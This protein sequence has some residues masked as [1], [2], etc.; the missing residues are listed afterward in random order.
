MLLAQVPCLAQKGTAETS[1]GVWRGIKP[2]AASLPCR[3]LPFFHSAHGALLGSGN[4][5]G[6]LIP[7]GHKV[8]R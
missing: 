2:Q 4:P 1:I 6:A 5:C 8:L 3:I 7:G